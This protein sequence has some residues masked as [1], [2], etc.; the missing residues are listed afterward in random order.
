QST[1]S[2]TTTTQLVE[3]DDGQESE[4]LL[5]LTEAA[6]K[7]IVLDSGATHHLVNNPDT[8]HPTSES[9]IKISTGGY[10]NFLNATAVGNATL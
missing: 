2:I 6:S 1:T 10:S 5:L 9:N 7:P 3:V 4:V 8:F